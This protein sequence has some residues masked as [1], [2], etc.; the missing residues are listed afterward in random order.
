MFLGPD[1]DDDLD[2]SY[3]NSTGDFELSGDTSEMT[4]IDPYLKI[5]KKFF[6]FFIIKVNVFF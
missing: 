1:P 4:T 2:S 6:L 5:C 3:T